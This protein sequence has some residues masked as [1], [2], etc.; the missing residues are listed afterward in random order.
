M[1]LKYLNM[2][3]K[4]VF[5]TGG[6]HKSPFHHSVTVLKDQSSKGQ[7]QV[8][9]LKVITMISLITGFIQ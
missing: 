4:S 2:K 9:S 1:F 5:S 8:L 3:P 6:T 7:E